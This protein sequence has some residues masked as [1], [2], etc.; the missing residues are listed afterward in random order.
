MRAC[1]LLHSWCRP[2]RL[3]QVG[4]RKQCWFVQMTQR[5][6]A[7]RCFPF[8]RKQEDVAYT[9]GQS[10]LV[11]RGAVA[12]HAHQGLHQ[13]QRQGRALLP[14]VVRPT[15]EKAGAGAARRAAKPSLPPS[16]QVCQSV[17]E[18]LPG[19][20]GGGQDA[21]PHQAVRL[22]YRCGPKT[23]LQPRGPPCGINRIVSSPTNDPPPGHRR[24]PLLSLVLCR[25]CAR[26]AHGPEARPQQGADRARPRRV[27]VAITA[28][29]AR[30][31]M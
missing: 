22:Q 12:A 13:G 25:E 21:H 5:A 20:A 2:A 7:M 27:R 8:E 19:G 3:A 24:L 1:V 30:T 15:A 17:P 6:L 28:L 31:T 4:G 26:P 9:C 10:A 14:S 11:C 16:P 18:L 29:L 23:P